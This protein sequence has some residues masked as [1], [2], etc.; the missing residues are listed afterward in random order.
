MRE[1]KRYSSSSPSFCEAK[2]ERKHKLA[3]F[4]PPPLST[5]FPFIE[6]QKT[7]PK[8]RRLL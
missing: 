6:K 3:H 8:R 7:K 1:K 5:F 2:K 4:P